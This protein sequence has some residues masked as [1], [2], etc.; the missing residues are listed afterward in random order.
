MHVRRAVTS[1][2]AGLALALTS[3]GMALAQEQPAEPEWLTPSGNQVTFVDAYNAPYQGD[4]AGLT[5]PAGEN[6]VIEVGASSFGTDAGG[7]FGSPNPGNGVSGI[8]HASDSSNNTMGDIAEGLS[9]QN[10]TRDQ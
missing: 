8:G 6:N 1:A 3:S 9:N 4:T 10:I 7:A 5:L 2:V